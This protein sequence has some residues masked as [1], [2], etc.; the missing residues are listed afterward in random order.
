MLLQL[1][2]LEYLNLS[3][4]DLSGLLHFLSGPSQL[5]QESLETLILVNIEQTRS[6]ELNSWLILSLEQ[7]TGL[8]E[9]DISDNPSIHVDKVLKAI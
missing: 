8:Y 3:H 2:C 6:I 4:N 1:E 5:F 9:L 7:L